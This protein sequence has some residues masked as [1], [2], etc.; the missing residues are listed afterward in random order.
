[1]LT[2][3]GTTYPT[4]TGT[5]G[6][7]LTINAAGSATW[8]ATTGTS[9]RDVVDET[10]VAGFTAATAGQTSFTLSQLPNA[11][12]KVKM[13]ING[14]RISNN[15]YSVNY[16]TKVVTYTPANNGTYAIIVGDRIQF[17]YFY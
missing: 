12:S 16:S 15:A 13:Y 10:G 5:T 1:V 9:V 17:D 7:V 8:T 6:Q 3:G 4:A 2:A 14:V 11:N